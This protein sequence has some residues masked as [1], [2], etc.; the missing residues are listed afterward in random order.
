VT[1]VDSTPGNGPLGGQRVGIDVVRR[2]STV[3]AEVRAIRGAV[4]LSELPHIALARVSG[5]AAYDVLDR[6]CPAA[7]YIR[8]GQLLHTLF[9]ADDGTPRADVYVGNDDGAY[10]VMADGIGNAALA[11]WLR[12]CAP[13][14]ADATVD[15]LSL[16][17]TVLSLNG[18]F[19]WEL[20]AAV[21]GP[22]I[23]G[24]PYLSFFRPDVGRVYFRAGKTGEFGYELIVPRERVR[25]TAETFAEKG[26]AFDLTF[27]GLDALA[28]CA[29]ENWFFDIHS[30]GRATLTPLELQLQWRLAH[31]K[32]YV[33]A[34]ALRARKQQGV[35]QRITGI[36]SDAPLE[37][38]DDVLLD[39]T[40]IGRVLE[41]IR[42]ITTAECIGVAL[43]DRAYAH[44][45]ISR[46]TARRG[47]RRVPLRTVSPPFV[48]NMSL[49]V[50]PQRHAYVDRDEIR[51]P[52][53]GR[54][55]K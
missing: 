16:T 30:P 34:A 11:E 49:F 7:L 47:D 31:D 25:S 33:G 36:E 17:H 2:Y 50:N 53:P 45:G 23:I 13:S 19:A 29:V 6:A 42:S 12:S 5:E 4:A 24:F 32:D 41:S 10:F 21:E 14:G 3:E 1:A 26:R 52:G 54:P 20:L 35:G 46:Y 51:F 28:H 39:D 18:P 37:A 48:N 15:D 43:L 44:S 9:L 55:K 27:A 8:D 22:E 38:G 40:R